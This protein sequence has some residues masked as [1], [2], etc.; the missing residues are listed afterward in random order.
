ME[1]QLKYIIDSLNSVNF[2]VAS[3]IN[4]HFIVIQ[5]RFYRSS[6]DQFSANRL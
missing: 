1:T 5:G 6:N 4:I 2:K 3:Y